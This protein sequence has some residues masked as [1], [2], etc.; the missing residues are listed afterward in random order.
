MF[1]N[2]HEEDN[3]IESNYAV[4]RLPPSTTEELAEDFQLV[5]SQL[6]LFKSQERKA[7]II[8][9]ARRVSGCPGVSF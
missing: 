2:I 4:L 6:S 7:K 8:W 5:K 3:V 9:D 1:K